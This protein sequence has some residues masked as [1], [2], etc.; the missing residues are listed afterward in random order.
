MNI[1]NKKGSEHYKREDATM[2]PWDYTHEYLDDDFFLGNVLK[3]ISRYPITGDREDLRKAIHYL[4]KR[5]ELDSNI[6]FVV[7]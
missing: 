2:E 1:A 7:M 5:L 4:E 6:E 3:Y